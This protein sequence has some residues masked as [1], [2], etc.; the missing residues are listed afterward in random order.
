MN[1]ITI[2]ATAAASILL[3]PTPHA[4]AQEVGIALTGGV[5]VASFSGTE[6]EFESIRRGSLGVT[7]TVGLH[8]HLGI[9]LGG[10]FSQKGGLALAEEGGLT[11][12]MTYWELSAMVRA[13]LPLAQDRIRPYLAAGPAMA[14][15]MRDAC[16]LK[17]AVPQGG[18][19]VRSCG[20]EDFRDRNFGVAGGAGLELQ[21][22]RS[23]GITLGAVHTHGLTNIVHGAEAGRAVG[24]L[25]HRTTTLRGGLVFKVW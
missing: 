22:S 6:F 9:E 21:L 23:M 8:R 13:T 12:H 14:S 15:A 2:I 17:F 11:L 7:A 19:L 16:N 10:A 18:W 5:N 4:S 20:L 3:L 1:P 25:K 24:E